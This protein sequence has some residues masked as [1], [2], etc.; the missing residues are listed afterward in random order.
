MTMTVSEGP[1]VRPVPKARI[2]K[3]AATE[4]RALARDVRAIRSLVSSLMSVSKDPQTVGTP[5]SSSEDVYYHRINV[6]NQVVLYTL[7][8]NNNVVIEGFR[9]VSAL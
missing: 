5:L 3:S 4:L 6:A 1:E 7:A 8:E 2:R 9:R